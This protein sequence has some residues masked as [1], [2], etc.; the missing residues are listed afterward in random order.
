MTDV[1]AGSL[2]KKKKID[3][4]IVPRNLKSKKKRKEKKTL[5]QEVKTRLGKVWSVL[6]EVIFDK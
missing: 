4:S 6:D 5:E 3:A 2:N 1:V